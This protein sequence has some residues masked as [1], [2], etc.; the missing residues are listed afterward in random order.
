MR[1]LDLTKPSVM[2]SKQLNHQNILL[3]G[4][5]RRGCS[6]FWAGLVFLARPGLWLLLHP[7][8]I[9]HLDYRPDVPPQVLNCPGNGLRNTLR[10][11][12][13]H[14]GFSRDKEEKEVSLNR[15][16]CLVKQS[17]LAFVFFCMLFQMVCS[18]FIFRYDWT[19]ANKNP[20]NSKGKTESKT[21]L[22]EH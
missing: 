6:A 2:D 1:L 7:G 8:G 19:L 13:H 11:A 21:E 18:D 3:I 9:L 16:T 5:H 15:T 12:H 22:K 20:L 4:S 10:Q 14:W 17:D